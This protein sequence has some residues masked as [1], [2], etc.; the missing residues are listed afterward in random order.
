MEFGSLCVNCFSLLAN[1][2]GRLLFFG[3]VARELCDAEQELHAAHFDAAA[4]VEQ[5]SALPAGSAAPYQT[6]AASFTV[7]RWFGSSLSLA[8]HHTTWGHQHRLRT[9]L[10]KQ[11]P[12]PVTSCGFT[13]PDIMYYYN[14]VTHYKNKIW[15]VLTDAVL[16]FGHEPTGWSDVWFV[17]EVTWVKHVIYSRPM[18]TVVQK[19]IMLRVL[20]EIKLHLEAFISLD[21]LNLDN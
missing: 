15:A 6:G 3:L 13:K 11:F 14:R 5:C 8:A 12:W 10:T 20:R 16:Y 17:G 19:L 21:M 2:G 1:A 4:V 18:L 7:A 9:H